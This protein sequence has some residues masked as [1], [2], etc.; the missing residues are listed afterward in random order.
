MRRFLG[1][2]MLVIGLAGIVLSITGAV[3]GRR[4]I[5]GIG[6]TL[7][8]NLQLTI[9]SLDT[10]NESLTLTRQTIRQIGAGL[11]TLKVTGE[12]AASS[13]DDTRPMVE[14]ISLVLTDDVAGGLETFQERLPDMVEVATTI[15]ETLTTLSNFRIDRTILGIPLRYDLGIN[16]NP[17][18]PFAQSVEELGAS[19]E[20]LPEELRVLETHLEVAGANLG[21]I[22]AN[23]RQLSEDLGDI[24]ETMD[25]LAP[26][27]DD[28]TAT[29]T[30]FAD[31]ARQIRA[32]LALQLDTFQT[33]WVVVMV[34]LALTQIAP[35]YLGYELVRRL[36]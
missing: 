35:L 2:V 12:Q 19:M 16:Y 4:L 22:S 33:V 3:V 27:L 11:E 34:W 36:R 17:Q 21:E 1:I 32:D 25:E 6:N 23:A 29:L 28:F 10:V 13:L 31:S 26:Q 30:E 5:G 18:V 15:D 24:N 20:G 14:Q 7:D 9:Q 8:A